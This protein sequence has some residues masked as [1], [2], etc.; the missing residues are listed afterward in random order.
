MLSLVTWAC[1]PS[2][3]IKVVEYWALPEGWAWWA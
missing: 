3:D 2:G 1:N